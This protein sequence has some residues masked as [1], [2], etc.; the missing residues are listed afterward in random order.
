M[1]LLFIEG[2]DKYGLANSGTTLSG[3]LTAGEWNTNTATAVIV[4]GLSAPGQAVNLTNGLL[5][6]TL[7]ANYG[8]LIGGFRFASSLAAIVGITFLDGA[9]AQAGISINTAGTISIKNGLYNSGTVI[10]TSTAS[11]TAN[12]T[13]Y[14][15]FDITFANAGSYTIWLNGISIL[16]GSAD[17]TATANA[18]ASVFQ[19]G[20]TATSSLTVDDLY[21]FDTTGSRNNAALNNSPRIETTFAASDNA[22][23]FAPGAAV[24]GST[25][26]AT[27]ANSPTANSLNL[28]R[29][30][31][32]VAMTINGV[33]LV[34]SATSAGASFRGVIYA[35]SAG[36]AGTLMSSG[37]TV[38]GATA[39]TVMTLPLTTPQ[40]L[41]AGT[42]YWIGYMNDTSVQTQTNDSSNAF[43][44]ANA[45]FASGAPTPAPAMTTG[46]PSWRMWGNVTPAT[47]NNYYAVGQVPPPGAASYVFDATVGHEDAYNFGAL[48]VMPATIHAVAVKGYVQ[49]SD[50]G[51]KTVS[52][53]V[54]SDSGSSAGQALGT[55]YG[56][57][58][59]F[60]EVDPSTSSPWTGTALN[61]VTS[62]LRIDS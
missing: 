48:G 55:S 1:A 10:A 57:L 23:Q 16:S 6:K 12:S 22:V 30:T 3:L 58:R 35:D 5:T 61:A 29:F 49:K 14:L 62:G 56:W 13:N 24:L 11:V 54:G 21:L 4:A 25:V 17:T 27:A 47:G 53:R 20:T 34:P 45:T 39:A 32:S 37:T 28:R 51:A 19:I 8:R 2:W 59:S 50:S 38:T 60:W 42:A 7:P 15:E 36:V 52:L 44:R 33:S 41:S 40:N 46:Q 43:S 26:Q 18:Y 31:P 9:T